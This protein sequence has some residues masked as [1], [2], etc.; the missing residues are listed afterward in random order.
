MAHTHSSDAYESSDFLLDQLMV[1]MG[2]G[3]NAYLERREAMKQ[4][5]QLESL[6]DAELAKRGLRRDTILDHV[7]QHLGAGTC[8]AA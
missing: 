6:S 7:V 5:R 2:L 4:L 8:A 3:F 1:E